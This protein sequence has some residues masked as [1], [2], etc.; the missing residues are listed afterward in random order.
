MQLSLLSALSCGAGNP[1]STTG[2]ITLFGR[3][4]LTNVIV[5]LNAFQQ[6]G[7]QK[8]EWMTM[9]DERVC[10]ICSSMDGKVYDTSR[11]HQA[12]RLGR[13]GV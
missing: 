6:I 5:V 10:L 9:E 1:S 13:A 12:A 2:R 8:L 7:I 11:F 3:G 4:A